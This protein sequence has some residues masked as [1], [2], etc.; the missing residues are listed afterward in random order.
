MEGK[1]QKVLLCQHCVGVDGGYG[2][3][4]GRVLV[5]GRVRQGGIFMIWIWIYVQMDLN[6]FIRSES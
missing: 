2:G 6:K 5:G 4:E 3:E 1:E